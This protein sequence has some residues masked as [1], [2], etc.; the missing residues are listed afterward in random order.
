MGAATCFF[1]EYVVKVHGGP[2]L[3]ELLRVVG[4]ALIVAFILGIAGDFYLKYKFGEEVMK[5]A[6]RDVM[7][8]MLGFLR[9]GQPVELRK[10]VS[11]FAGQS[12][13]VRS[14]RIRVNFSWAHKDR[15]MRL[16]VSVKVKGTCID[17]N[18]YLP[19][20][21]LWSVASIRGYETTYLHYSLHCP[22]ADINVSEDNPAELVPFTT[23]SPHRLSLNQQDLLTHR[24]PH[25]AYIPPGETFDHG[26]SIRTF[27]RA[28]GFVPL[29]HSDFAILF[30]LELTGEALPGLEV[31]VFHPMSEV[32]EQ[33]WHYVGED[34]VP[35]REWHNV[36]PGQATI[37]S[38]R[39]RD[40]SAAGVS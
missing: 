40:N 28:T 7:A 38:W 20:G 18:G 29:M 30:R 12:I 39:P 2:F 6:V 26:R 14:T 25:G 27:L 16:D 13:Y 15:V 23:L 33:E 22:V 3:H 34:P 36:T 24:V 1:L 17:D 32:G 9:G 10:A 8:E 37:V 11:R 21:P 19:R 5:K 31:S 4:D 35:V